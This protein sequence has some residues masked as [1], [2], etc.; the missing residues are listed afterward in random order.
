MDYYANCNLCPHHCGVNRHI[1]HGKCGCGDEPIIPRA[2]LHF[3]E[4]PCISG[5]RGSGTVFFA[6]CSLHCCF[7]QNHEISH[8]PLAAKSSPET[9]A[10]IFLKLQTDGAHNINL[11]TADHF[12]PDVLTA[13]DAVKA[14]I[15]IPIVY[16]CSGYTNIEGINL[17]KP[18]VDI[19]MPDFKFYDSKISAKY[20][21][22]DDYCAVTTDAIRHICANYNSLSF[23]KNGILTS[24][25]IIR[26]LIL[27][28]HYT[29]SIAVLNQI[30]VN[31]DVNNVI[32]SLMSQYTPQEVNKYPEL[33]RR[34]SS[35]EYKKVCEHADNLG[36]EYQY[37]QNR[38]SAETFY[39]PDFS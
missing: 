31:V 32:L 35:Y 36:F 23:D 10:S 6:G 26:H 25:V 12:L 38:S 17:L 30:A 1:T 4:E 33:G 9:L 18:Y 20:A 39:T 7:C 28:T 11:V 5:S 14:E 8:S 3:H 24:G 22:A 29:D 15:N 2:A 27:P 16:N 13:L 19:F 21:G 34:V 37:T